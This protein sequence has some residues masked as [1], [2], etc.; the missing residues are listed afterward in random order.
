[1]TF[2]R[3]PSI[4]ADESRVIEAAQALSGLDTHLWHDLGPT[5]TCS[6]TETFVELLHATGLHSAARCLLDSH[7]HSD[8]AEE[9]QRHDVLVAR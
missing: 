3:W 5:L 7:C 6:E 9:K 8:E 2:A 1:M 4:G